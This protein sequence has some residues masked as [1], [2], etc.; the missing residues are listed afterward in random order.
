MAAAQPSSPAESSGK[1]QPTGAGQSSGT[2]QPGPT[3]I[4]DGDCAFCTRCAD[5]LGRRLGSC[6]SVVPWQH[7]DL[8]SLGIAVERAERE[9]LWVEQSPAVPPQVRG[10]AGAIAAAL[11]LG[12][13]PAW[14]VAGRVLAAWPARWLARSTYR[15]VARFRH[16]LPGGTSACAVRPAQ[17]GTGQPA[18]RT[19][20][21]LD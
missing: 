11:H 18:P 19:S 17:R 2:G 12:D 10:G 3:L 6:V 9:V 4:F 16:R 7:T 15:L 13:A 14:R 20:Q 21:R 1:A 5:W 8:A